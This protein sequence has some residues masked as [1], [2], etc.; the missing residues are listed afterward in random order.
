MGCLSVKYAWYKIK[1]FDG[2]LQADTR[3]NKYQKVLEV[4]PALL[5]MFILRRLLHL[6][7]EALQI[8]LEGIF[9]YEVIGLLVK[10]Y[11]FC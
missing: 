4:M 10:T 5:V 6:F 9:I 11:F 2:F 8:F 3:I 1:S 7:P